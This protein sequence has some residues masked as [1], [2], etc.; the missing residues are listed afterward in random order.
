[1][2]NLLFALAYILSIFLVYKNSKSTNRSIGWTIGSVLVPLIIPIIY[3]ATRKD[4]RQQSQSEKTTG[5]FH[6]NIAGI[7][8]KNKDGSDRR[9]VIAKCKEGDSLQLRREPDNEYDPNAVAVFTLHGKQMGYLYRE[10]AAEIAR[11]LD[12]GRPV[13]AEIVKI[14]RDRDFDIKRCLIK[15]TKQ[16]A[17]I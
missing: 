11:E 2:D 8:Y 10:E 15:L 17:K 7:T 1:M 9:D 14:E 3:Y 6:T 4:N 13:D 12:S 16:K 5:I